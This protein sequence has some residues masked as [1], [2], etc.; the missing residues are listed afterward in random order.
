[1]PRPHCLRSAATRRLSLL[2]ATLL[3]VATWP[4]LAATA[5]PPPTPP[6]ASPP[7]VALPELT[8]RPAEIEEGDV[9]ID[10]VRFE[11]ELATPQAKA[12]SVRYATQDGS[13]VARSGDYDAIADVLTLDPG[14]TVATVDVTIHG[15]T[16]GEPDEVFYLALSE[17]VGVTLAAPRVVGM[18]RDDDGT[19]PGVGPEI[20]I[21]DA[22][23][24]EGNS[25]RPEL[26]F[27]LNLSNAAAR[28]V[29]VKYDT[30]DGR[31]TAGEDYRAAS[32]ELRFPVGTTSLVLPLL[33]IGDLE[34][35]GDEDFV[36]Q[37]ADP[38]GGSL[39]RDKAYGLILDDDGSGGV[40][41]EGVGNSDRVG[42]PG[43]MVVLQVRLRNAAGEPVAGTTINWHLD[44]TGTLLDG[45]A[46]ATDSLGI[47]TQR[48]E[49][50]PNAGR[51]AVS[52]VGPDRDQVVVFQVGVSSPP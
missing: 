50:G 7:A 21:R 33:A 37:L 23:V 5:T 18:I 20:S 46:T 15:D 8:I 34:T 45:P 38:V 43:G 13:A 30:A 51:S 29:T 19:A 42:R 22:T 41:L 2:F 44:G 52:A 14:Q 3:G 24:A 26:R 1:M 6:T 4:L 11:V 25:G 9:G 32:G 48:L 39:G 12:V 35:E 16:D 31:A 40:S 17:P 28:I 36:V 10:V 49:L 27:E 47:G